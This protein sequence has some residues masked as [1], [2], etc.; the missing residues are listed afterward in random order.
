MRSSSEAQFDRA[1]L[2]TPYDQPSG[3][4]SAYDYVN[5]QDHSGKIIPA[6]VI[7]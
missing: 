1:Q 5:H 2:L 6:A 7:R 4:P 3:T